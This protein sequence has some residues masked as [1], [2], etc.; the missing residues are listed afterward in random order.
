M[1]RANQMEDKRL[2]T[3]EELY[4][5]RQAGRL[6]ADDAAEILGVSTRTFRRCRAGFEEEVVSPDM[7][8]FETDADR[9]STAAVYPS[10]GHPITAFCTPGISPR[11]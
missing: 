8:E 1:T 11:V 4:N 2:M 6:T 3:F 10:S 5:R 7:V 9:T